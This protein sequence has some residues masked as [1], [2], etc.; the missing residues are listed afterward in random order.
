MSSRHRG[1]RR[2]SRARARLEALDRWLE[3]E[4]PEWTARGDEDPG[5]ALLEAFALELADLEG[6]IDRM[7]RRAV[8]ELLDALG[9]EARWPTPVRAAVALAA[10]EGLEHAVAVAAGTAVTASRSPTAR[11]GSEAPEDRLT[12]ETETTGWISP[13]RLRVAFIQQG[14]RRVD[15]PILAPTARDGATPEPGPP[16]PLFEGSEIDHHLYFGDPAWG[17]LQ[18]SRDDIVLEWPG[19]PPFVAQGRWEYGVRGA[20]RELPVEFQIIVDIEG[21]RQL[22]MRVLGPLPDLAER[23]LCSARMPWIRLSLPGPGR[24]Q[25]SPPR[26]VWC[27]RA[28]GRV[29]EGERGAISPR[30]IRRVL[31]R[32]GG[33]WEDHSFAST[34]RVTAARP[35]VQEAPSVYLG[36]DQPLP[37]SLYWVAGD[38]AT[39]SGPIPPRIEWERSVSGG[40]RAFDVHDDTDSFTASG[41][42]A[43]GIQSGWLRREVA[44]ER[45]FWVRARWVGGAYPDAPVVR[46]VV[47]G[48]VGVVEGRTLRG[49]VV[50]L[51]FSGEGRRAELPLVAAGAC[52]PF[53]ELEVRTPGGGWRSLRRSPEGEAPSSDEFRLRRRARGAVE[54][55][56]AAPPGG[57]LTVRIPEVRVELG[58]DPARRIVG[59]DVLE[60]STGALG[61]LR[62]V[63]PAHGAGHRENL[64][65][66]V[67][68][69][70]AERATGGR[71][72]TG[73]DI[74]RLV[75]ALDP[76]L[77][78][79]EAVPSPRDPSGIE[80]VVVGRGPVGPG[81]V[82]VARLERIRRYLQERVPLGRVVRVSEPCFVPHVLLVD[83]GVRAA[84]SAESA[85]GGSLSPESVEAIVRR[86][87]SYIDPLGG[88]EH[89][90]G[91]AL[92]KGLRTEDLRTIMLS[93]EV[94]GPSRPGEAP[95]AGLLASLR[96]ARL[97]AS[98]GI[99]DGVVVEPTPTELPLLDRWCPA[100]E[101]S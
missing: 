82:S 81:Q 28:P 39:G 56:L 63:L 22:R 51:E 15:L 3:R 78:R 37:A 74:R 70:R 80:V 19:V 30:R 57:R 43:W 85:E 46:A 53:E 12:F 58:R 13:A 7:P 61:G 29:S 47:P 14:D 66:L 5:R 34:R 62:Q 17:L 97:D 84:E 64:G 92:G 98:G 75:R 76:A 4:M 88:G 31:S 96:V 73:D 8:A 60:S 27:P 49:R 25:W 55:E 20:W 41:T 33:R 91:Y 52:E 86:V 54:V 83:E 18:R 23:T 89:G 67:R 2:L 50:D 71:A 77:R 100:S 1:D 90:R 99:L 93:F 42:I 87:R 101:T 48:A 24:L 40:F 16:R 95:D 79:V 35:T 68:R 45:L 72:V 32:G 9:E 65:D 44:G 6:E 38:A 21:R 26:I 94:S 69:R 10:K 36:W 11:G 59:L